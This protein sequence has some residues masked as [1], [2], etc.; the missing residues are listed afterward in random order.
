MRNRKAD[1][2]FAALF[3]A[4]MLLFC[5][6]MAAFTV[7][8]GSLDFQRE[9]LGRSL[10]TSYGRERKQQAEYDQVSEE[11]PLTRAELE[12]TQPLADAAATRVTQLKSRRKDL[13]AE[14]KALE[15]APEKEDEPNE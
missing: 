14:K 12:E 1:R 2:R 7:L 3:T 4:G 15:E 10:E 13:R 11:L 6:C 8:R 5:A 9:D